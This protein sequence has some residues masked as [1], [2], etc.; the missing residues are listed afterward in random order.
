MVCF[1]SA[2]KPFSIQSKGYQKYKQR[3][4]EEFKPY[5]SMY[6]ELPL[7]ENIYSKI[8]YIH[9]KKTD[10][11]VDNMSKP[12]V[13]AFRGIIYPDDNT[14][15]HRICSKIMLEDFQTYEISIDDIPSEIA[16]K[17]NELLE[18]GSEH[19]VYYEVNKFCKNM[20]CIGEK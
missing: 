9:S 19:I 12:F 10:I 11:D 20:V 2:L 3:L 18:N 5:K 7:R 6:A 13:D 8:I 14:I 16:E 1:V 17:F 15:N 4:I